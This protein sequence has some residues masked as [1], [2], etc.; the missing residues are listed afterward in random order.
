MERLTIRNKGIAFWADSR[1]AGGGYRMDGDL[2]DQQR[3]DRLAAY[4]DTGLMPEEIT[5]EKPACVFYCNRRCNLNDD[6]C[7]EG[8]GCLQE[9]SAEAAVHLL[10]SVQPSSPLTLA[11]LREMD[12]EPVLLETGWVN[13]REQLIAIWE[14]L[15]NHDDTA[16]Y[17]TRRKRGFRPADYG[18]TWL[19]YRRRP[20]EA[21]T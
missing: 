15:V 21:Q 12:G 13:I 8:P 7:H 19:A 5:T 11:E 9:L 18:T 16:F 14:I 4:E 10:E 3:L 2:K 20:E 17:F 6:W 1:C